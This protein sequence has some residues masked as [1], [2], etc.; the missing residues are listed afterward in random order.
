MNTT[1]GH[2][3]DE[4]PDP[5][6][7]VLESIAG[8][9][10]DEVQMDSFLASLRQRPPARS[11]PL[12]STNSMATKPNHNRLLIWLAT[13]AALIAI[14]FGLQS[15]PTAN[16]L[17]KI[18][19]AL[20]N[21]PCI[22]STTIIDNHKSERWQVRSTDQM[23]SRDDRRIE[24]ADGPA[25]TLTTYDHRTRELVR[26]PLPEQRNSSLLSELVESLAAAGKGSIPKLIRGM[27]IQ[28]AKVLNTSG[29][30]VLQLELQ[31]LDGALSGSASITLQDNGDLPIA[32][33]ASFSKSSMSQKIETTWEYPPS[34]PADIFELGVPQGTPLI[35]RIPTPAVKQL[36]ADV[37]KGRLQFDDYRAV[38][39]ASDSERLHDVDTYE[40]SLVSKKAN[41]LV[42]LRN[43]DDLVALEGQ[44]RKKVASQ[45]LAYPQMIKWVPAHLI[46]GGTRYSFSAETAGGVHA[47]RI[48][49][50]AEGFT[51]PGYDRVPHLVGRP[52]TGIG[53]PTIGATLELSAEGIPADCVLLRTH[54]TLMDEIPQSPVQRLRGAEYWISRTKDFLVLRTQQRWEDGSTSALTLGE[55]VQSPNGYWYPTSASR[56]RADSS[57]R[58]I[59][60][61]YHVDFSEPLS[62]AMFDL[63]EL[64]KMLGKEHRK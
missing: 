32:G 18:A 27:A 33:V 26:S 14:L 12:N 47:S 28:S 39:F 53:R 55:L 48:S 13:T 46:D 40:V 16:A 3:E 11:L 24:F 44:S 54:Q 6:K 1:V 36:V 42:L 58:P 61:S 31:S 8:D 17:E 30:R 60:D 29:N 45:I 22:K 35:D 9:Q 19:S 57:D 51:I 4:L 41:R 25:S 7:S 43:A 20:A 49:D 59:V 64:V 23:A 38:V 10:P 52:S 5:L 34:G 62:D 21:V 56:S 37:Y 2:A 50:V 63:N 15:L